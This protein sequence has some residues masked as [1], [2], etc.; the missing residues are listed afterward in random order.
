MASLSYYNLDGKIFLDSENN[1][2]V[3]NRSFRYGDGFFETIKLVDGIIELKELHFERIAASLDTLGFVNAKHFSFDNLE[4]QIIELATKNYH[5]HLGRIRITF[6]RADAGLYEVTNFHPHILIQSF[7]LSETVNKLNENGLVIDVYPLAKKSC[8]VFSNIKSNNYLQYAMAALWAKENKLNDA[9]LLNSNNNIAD[10][11]IANVFMIKNNEIKTP[12]LTEGCIDGVMRKHI[13]TTLQKNNIKVV[14]TIVNV[15][16]I[17]NAD[18][19]FL[20]NAI[21]GIMWVRQLGDS[22]YVNFE[23]RRIYKILNT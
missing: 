14:E 7:K 4:M 13:I 10:S 3:N 1:I 15:E 22:N 18:E 23:T 16:D 11:T 2:S 20:T 8:D 21:K 5:H 12:A 17:A 6:Y 19:V 9:L